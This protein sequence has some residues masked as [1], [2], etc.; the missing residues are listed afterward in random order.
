MRRLLGFLCALT[1]LFVGF[2][3]SAAQ[4]VLPST[5][6]QAAK[7]WLTDPAGNVWSFGGATFHG[8]LGGVALTKPI[9]ATASTSTSGGYWMVASD[10][11]VFTFGDAEYFGS[12]GAIKL[13][14]P[15]VGLTPTPTGDGYW[16]VASDGGIFSFGDA[17]FFGS[18]GAI[19]L[20]QPIVSATAT[21]DGKGYWLTASDGG[22]F[23]F[24][25]AGFYGSDASASPE[26]ALRVVRSKTGNGYWVVRENG[27]VTAFGDATG[28]PPAQS[29]LWTPSTPGDQAVAF[30]FAQLGKPYI[31]G[32]NG[33]VGY[34]CSGLVLASWRTVGRSFARVANDQYRS[35]GVPVAMTDLEPGDLVFWGDN[36]DDWASVYHAAMYVGGGNIVESTGD[37]V[38]LNTLR[39]WGTNDVMPVGRRP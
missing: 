18:T 32:G 26:A 28:T 29:V 5:L 34:D 20:A 21:K 19:K 9:V 27:E 8:S 36:L 15:I 23:N 10:G 1:A 31:W 3:V 37:H 12:T 22:V 4:A 11:G 17:A 25:T 13:N 7:F 39:Q 33:P 2:P 6:P 35:V 30:A 24:G 16:L 14:Q 38:Q